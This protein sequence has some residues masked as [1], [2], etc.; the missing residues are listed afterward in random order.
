[1]I[2]YWFLFAY[3]TA[4]S[5]FNT[6]GVS[7]DRS[8]VRPLLLIGALLI[9]LLVGFRYEVGG[10][11]RSYELMFSF[12]GYSDLARAL[13]IG[14]PGYQLLN[15][16]VQQV[17]GEL[18]VV[19]L[20]CGSIFTWGL[21]QLAKVQPDAWLAI[22]VA[23]PYLIIVVAMGY[24]RQAVAIG[25]LMAGLAA[26]QQ[27]GTVLRFAAYVA[28]AALFHRSAVV[29]LPLVIFAGER[30]RLLNVIG[31]LAAFAVLFDMLLADSVHGFVTNYIKA[32]YSSQGAVIRVVMNLVPAAIFLARPRTLG[33]DDH[34]RQVW[35]YFSYAAIACLV[36][37]LVLPSSTAVDRIALYIAPL[38]IVILA[39]LGALSRLQPFG[40]LLVIGYSFAVQFVWLNYAA[41]APAWLPYRFFPL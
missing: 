36:L 1:M 25:V 39:R 28:V 13:A 7:K 20:A 6:Q 38:Q 2:P 33:L 18:W 22:L 37:L 21:Y 12:A 4:G 11:W 31:G 10:D 41:N 5:L 27:G 14:D 35:R 15:W 32:E 24:S 23:V 30:N 3:F 16:T 17:G 34:D 26:V 29:V 9:T 40:R 19:N 8:E